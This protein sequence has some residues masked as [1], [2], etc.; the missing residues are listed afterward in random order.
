[1]KLVVEG[2]LVTPVISK[3]SQFIVNGCKVKI[4]QPRRRY[5]TKINTAKPMYPYSFICFLGNIRIEYKHSSI[6]KLKRKLSDLLR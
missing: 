3:K 1:M 4:I 2:R 5:Y 6:T